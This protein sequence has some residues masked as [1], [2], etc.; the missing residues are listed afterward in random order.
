MQPLLSDP[1]CSFDVASLAELDAVGE[2]LTKASAELFRMEM[3]KVKAE[4]KAEVDKQRAKA[5]AVIDRERAKAKAAE[6]KAST[7]EA[8]TAEA[9]AAQAVMT[10]QVRVNDTI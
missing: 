6:D 4:S 1:L 8:K 5:K 7:A 3:E 10:A 2:D 9:K